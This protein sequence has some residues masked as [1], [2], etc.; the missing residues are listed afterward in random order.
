[1]SMPDPLSKATR[2][3]QIAERYLKLCELA[4]DPNIRA[5]YSQMAGRYVVLARAER[6]ARADSGRFHA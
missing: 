1:M 5:L 2:F 6:R 4:T 3:R